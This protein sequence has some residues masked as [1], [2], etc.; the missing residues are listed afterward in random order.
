[1]SSKKPNFV[2][3]NKQNW[4]ARNLFNFFLMNEWVNGMQYKMFG[5]VFQFCQ[6]VLHWADRTFIILIFTI[7]NCI[8]QCTNSYYDWWCLIV[9]NNFFS[10]VG[11]P[12][13]DWVKIKFDKENFF[14]FSPFYQWNL[15]HCIMITLFSFLLFVCHVLFKME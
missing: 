15:L 6:I 11:L 5:F 12:I 8:Q 7:P 13:D 9:S 14:I 10:K 2:A 4:N 1:M 3:A